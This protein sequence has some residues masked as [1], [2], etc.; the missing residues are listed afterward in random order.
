MNKISLG[1]MISLTV[2]AVS[3]MED[4]SNFRQEMPRA[5]RSQII[6]QDVLKDSQKLA[7]IEELNR[8]LNKSKFFAH[9]TTCSSV[10][11]ILKRTAKR[12]EDFFSAND[13]VRYINM[14]VLNHEMQTV[15][16]GGRVG[17][18]ITNV[19]SAY[20]QLNETDKIA[21]S[22][23][24]DT[25]DSYIFL[26]QKRV[27]SLTSKQTNEILAYKELKEILSNFVKN[28]ESI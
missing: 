22:K 12:H 21:V 7:L 1:L 15:D 11:E 25:L 20:D 10:R 23:I 3:A 4:D 28:F 13:I 5:R 2:P 9:E 18:P 24:K 6:E 8:N 16:M 26:K 14:I 17:I 19:I 27:L